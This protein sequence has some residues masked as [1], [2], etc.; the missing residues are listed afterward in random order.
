MVGLVLTTICI[1]LVFKIADIKPKYSNEVVE[2]RG[3]LVDVEIYSVTKP[4]YSNP[5]T[6]VAHSFVVL[7][8]NGSKEALALDCCIAVAYRGP[9]VVYFKQNM[10]SKIWV[11]ITI[12]KVLRG[13]RNRKWPSKPKDSS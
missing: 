5:G 3:E 9:V 12:R 4:S 7:F 13:N 2:R 6:E 8:E 10:Q 11:P 1:T